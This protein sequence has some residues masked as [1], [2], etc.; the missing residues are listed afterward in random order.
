M[1]A[2][3]KGIKELFEQESEL[4]VFDTEVPTEPPDLY[5]VYY[6]SSPSD[7]SVRSTARP[8][9]HA[10]RLTTLSIG[11]SPD[12]CRWVVEKVTKCLEF[13]APVA[14]SS[15]ITHSTFGIVRPDDSINPPAFTCTDL[16]TF[17]VSQ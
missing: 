12:E 14:G 16:W 13:H 17:H 1:R 5:V 7:R 8:G 11:T 4:H 9:Q 6:L 2:I 15:V 3:A 10:Y